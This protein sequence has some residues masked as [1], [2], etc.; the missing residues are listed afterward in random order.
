[1]FSTQTQKIE[2]HFHDS[3]KNGIKLHNSSF[4]TVTSKPKKIQCCTVE[5]LKYLRTWYT[6][7]DKRH[8]HNLCKIIMVYWNYNY[9]YNYNL[10]LYL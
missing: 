2:P 3:N 5:M 8:S 7:T 4:L 6:E 10:Y 1:M 9:N